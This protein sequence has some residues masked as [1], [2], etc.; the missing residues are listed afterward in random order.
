MRYATALQAQ[1]WYPDLWA[2]IV[3]TEAQP[4]PQQLARRG[5][6]SGARPLRSY[7]AAAAAPPS[8]QGSQPRSAQESQANT[9]A[10]L[11]AISAARQDIQRSAR[12][13]A[14]KAAEQRTEIKQAVHSEA[15]A[16]RQFVDTRAQESDQLIKEG[17]AGDGFA[18]GEVCGTVQSGRGVR[19][20]RHCLRQS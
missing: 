18:A 20:S 13:E 19:L 1:S 14:A 9:Q 15:T 10:I 8:S 12:E 4:P 16:T 6:R 17:T 3:F 2:Q 7:A 11:G 5:G